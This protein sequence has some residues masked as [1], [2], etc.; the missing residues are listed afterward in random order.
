MPVAT[1]SVR[2][3]HLDERVRHRSAVGVTDLTAHDDALTVGLDVVLA[4][5]VGVTGLDPVLAEERTCQLRHALRQDDE[6]LRGSTQDGRAV[7][8]DEQGLDPL[9]RWRGVARRRSAVA[10]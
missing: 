8:R 6:W 7:R 5:Q 3:P 9:V 4:G 10:G 1:G 2:L